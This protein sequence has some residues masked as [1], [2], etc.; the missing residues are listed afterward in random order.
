MKN[1]TIIRW[2]LILSLSFFSKISLAQELNHEAT[3]S[4]QEITIDTLE[5]EGDTT[6]IKILQRE[7]RI[8]E[9]G[10]ESE[11]QM[12]VVDPEVNE[13][14]KSEIGK[15]RRFKGHWSGFELGINNYLNSDFST[16]LDPSMYFMELRSSK[17]INVNINFLQYD[18]NIAGDNFGFLTGM[19]FE[20]NHYRFKNNTTIEVI[21]GSIAGI[22]IMT[23]G[24]LKT[25]L[26]TT[27]LTV[28]LLLEYQTPQISRRQRIH[29][30]AGLIGGVKLGAYTKVVSREAGNRNKERVRDDFYLNPFR[31]GLTFRAGF[32]HLNL[33]ANYYLTPLFAKGKG[34]ELYP[35]SIG[36]SL[37]G[38]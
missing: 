17:S 20:F 21:A 34:P 3:G 8:I 9:K 5:L 28:P 22:E 12:S 26:T 15:R 14:T 24:V 38:F 16:S 25:K 37:I 36:L 33:Y 4:L 13:E 23:P 32:G 1:I 11:I 6:R 31:Y 35:F 27:Y 18:F 10:D 19:G 29:L 2:I 30:S 7:I